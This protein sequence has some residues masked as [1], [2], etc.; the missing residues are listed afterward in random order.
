MQNKVGCAFVI[1][2]K[3][4]DNIYKTFKLNPETSIFMAEVITINQTLDYI[5]N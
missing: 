3:K 4:I 1:Y 5:N 2:Y